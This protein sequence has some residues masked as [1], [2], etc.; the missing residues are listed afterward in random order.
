MLLRILTVDAFITTFE[1]IQNI[2]K[3]FFED[4][5]LA[6]KLVDPFSNNVPLLCPLKTSENTSFSDVFRAY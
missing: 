6:E 4:E 3:S 5:I 2:L 1:A